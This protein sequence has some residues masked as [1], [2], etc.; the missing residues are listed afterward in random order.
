MAASP[1]SGLGPRPLFDW[2]R[3]CKLNVE[4]VGYGWQG[5]RLIA[6]FH[7][8]QDTDLSCTQ[9]RASALARDVKH[10]KH[11]QCEF[12]GEYLPNASKMPADST[13]LQA[14]PP[15]RRTFRT[16]PG[17]TST[18]RGSSYMY[19][20][21][22]NP[23][24]HATLTLPTPQLHFVCDMDEPHV[25]KGLATMHGMLQQMGGAGPMPSL[26][27][28]PAGVSYPLAGSCA[29]CERDD[30]ASE[31]ES[32]QLDRCSGCRMT[33]YCG[34]ECQRKDWPR[35]KVTCAMVH[36]VKFENWD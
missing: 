4:L 17:T 20:P 2:E 25:R 29:F 1:F 28:R 3:M 9:R 26:P 14:R 16:S 31:D 11:W 7:L 19:V 22:T 34:V 24:A 32:A 6:R 30:T 18:R 5:K 23:S 21:R 10:S 8:P 33:R 36:S 15:A 35:H 12:C 13:H 27:K